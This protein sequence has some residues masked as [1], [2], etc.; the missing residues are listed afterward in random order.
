MAERGAWRALLLA[1]ALLACKG[2]S[3]T[4]RLRRT[5][6]EAPVQVVSPGEPGERRRTNVDEREPND[7]LA[8]ELPL[9]AA[10]QGRLASSADL[11]RFRITVASAGM[12][13]VQVSA[14]PAVDLVLELRSSA[15]AV[16][17]KSDRGGAG[18]LE[19][20]AG[21]PVEPG[22]YE[23]V[24]RA[25]VKPPAKA[26]KQQPPP[27]AAPAP[28]GFPSEPYELTVAMSEPGAEL[29]PNFDAGTASE[30]AL[31]EP[32]TGR[33]GWSGDVDVWKLGIEVLAA[34]D[35][36]DL[37]LA[38]VE[39]LA[40]QLELRDGLG[41]PIAS[42]KGGKGQPLAVRG[43]APS[44]DASTPPF[45]YVAVSAD[46]SHPAQ[47]YQ[48]SAVVRVREPSDERE[49][50]DAPE[51]AQPLPEEG[52]PQL[53]TLDLGDVDCFAVPAAA[54]RR[55][56]EVVVDPGDSS[57]GAMKIAVEVL[58]GARVVATSVT[59]SAAAAAERVLAEVPAGAVAVVRVRGAARAGPPG[60]Y[61]VSWTEA[62]GDAMPPEEAAAP[63]GSAAR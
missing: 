51:R 44:E 40:L 45:L 19:G 58:L 46:R 42:R 34:T 13:E 2:G 60:P 28:E 26:K 22:G 37:T 24:L 12:L 62:L 50:N 20:L 33:L 59:P 55:R 54:T 15:G 43:F 14:V 25:F 41:R 16:L 52:A 49:S 27:A 6:E 18:V 53:A 1:V 4:D 39:G 35:A 36:L 8:N 47:G 9:G 3:K 21:F 31:G 38:A 61:R 29:E 57:A 7:E 11:D 30:L 56:I 17:A 48:L 23:L 63:S 10:A 5:S 32:A